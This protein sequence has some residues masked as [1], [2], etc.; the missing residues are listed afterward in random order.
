MIFQGF[1]QPIPTLSIIFELSLCIDSQWVVEQRLVQQVYLSFIITSH[2]PSQML[3]KTEILQKTQKGCLHILVK[4]QGVGLCVQFL[5]LDQCVV[6]NMHWKV[7]CFCRSHGS[8]I[9]C[10][11]MYSIYFGLFSRADLAMCRMCSIHPSGL[12][13][14]T[15][16]MCWKG[17]QAT[18]VPCVIFL[19]WG[20]QPALITLYM[21]VENP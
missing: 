9:C 16:L 1:A 18:M 10:V 21:S 12:R 20:S 4:S 14:M 7:L 15:C 11:L 3:L 2:H 13:S 17:K 5:N 19:R 6:I 8:L